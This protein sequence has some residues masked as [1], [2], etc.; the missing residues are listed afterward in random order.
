MT[1]R[2]PLD[3]QW[4]DTNSQTGHNGR[5]VAHGQLGINDLWDPNTGLSLS[6][7]QRTLFLFFCFFVF[8]PQASNAD[9][10]ELVYQPGKR[11]YGDVSEH[12]GS[13][14]GCDYRRRQ[15]AIGFPPSEGTYE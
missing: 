9:E 8:F 11:Y 2:T 15:M 3:R 6:P 4:T 14:A 12:I 1:N 5:A 10:A 7:S 13:L